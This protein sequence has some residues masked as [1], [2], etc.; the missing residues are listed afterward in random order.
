MI[1]IAIDGPS[2]AGKSTIA[3]E[4]AKRLG[5]IYLD[6]GAMYRAIGLKAIRSDIDTDDVEGIKSFI[7]DTD[8]RIAYKDGVQSI[9]L[10][11][12]DVSEAIREHAVSKAASN[13]SKI[14]DVRIKLVAMQRVIAD[15]ED[16]VLDGRDI[17]SY[18]LPHAEYKFYLT[19]AA[20]ERASRRYKELSAKGQDVD[21]KTILNDI[22]D[23][24]FNDMN[25]DFAPLMQTDDSV[26]IDSTSMTIDQ[27]IDQILAYIKR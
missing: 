18:V 22:N 2:G 15:S 14:A 8:I 17:T 11:G 7:N 21:Y 24:D 3:K 23:R 19:A 10:D 9:F 4:L 16:M 13:V 26:F 5:I 6:T 12:E 27:A 20:E 1:N 25:R